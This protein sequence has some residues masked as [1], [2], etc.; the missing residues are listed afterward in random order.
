MV[1]HTYSKHVVSKGVTWI[2]HS[3]G[4]VSAPGH[5]TR[6][7]RKRGGKVQEFDITFPERKISPCVARNGYAEV[8]VMKNGKRVKERLHRLV[9]LAFVEGHEAGL[10]VNHI[11][12]N[13]LNNAA[14]NLEWVSLA[15]NTQ[16]QW[17]SGLVDLRG[18]SHPSAKLTTKRVVYIRRLLSQGI[19]AHT[20]A[21]VAGVSHRIVTRIR[22]G[23]AWTAMA[24]S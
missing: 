10:T 6:Y 18:E 2:V 1:G 23:K 13:K 17:E 19:S 3:D 5:T 24:D 7:R 20:L 15:R 12:G 4:A 11:D 8:A 22:D 14:S 21:V 9:A 16:H